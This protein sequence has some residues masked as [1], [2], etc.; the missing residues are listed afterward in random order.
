M[1]FGLVL[2]VIGVV[3][4]LQNLGYLS[5]DAW[6]IIWPIIIIVIGLGFLFKRSRTWYGWHTL[7]DHEEH[8]EE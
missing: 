3:F 8:K 7:H 4:L 6:K 2:I 5:S 1:F